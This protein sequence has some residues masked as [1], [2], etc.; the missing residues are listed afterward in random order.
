[1]SIILEE[2]TWFRTTL[3]VFCCLFFIN[4]GT[5]VY[6]DNCKT[7]ILDSQG[8]TVKI[9]FF[10][11]RYTWDEFKTKALIRKSDDKTGKHFY[12]VY[13]VFSKKEKPFDLKI[14]DP[15]KPRFY[16]LNPAKYFLIYLKPTNKKSHIC[17]YSKTTAVNDE[18]FFA[19]MSEWNVPLKEAKEY[20][21]L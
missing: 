14:F 20:W 11:L 1:M 10:K 8:M 6:F 21:M 2:N 9:F 7:I 18:L 3:S 19:K 5:T 16:S 4:V 17:A 13:A 12:N 15:L